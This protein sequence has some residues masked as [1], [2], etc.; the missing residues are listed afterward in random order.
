MPFDAMI[1]CIYFVHFV[2]LVVPEQQFD[3]DELL[4]GKILLHQLAT[5]LLSWNFVSQ[6][7]NTYV[8]HSWILLGRISQYV[9]RK[10][11]WTYPLNNTSLI[12]KHLW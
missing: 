3:L 1:V 10:I 7:M 11:Y 8:L 2:A 4:P 5:F 12:V 6:A 9:S